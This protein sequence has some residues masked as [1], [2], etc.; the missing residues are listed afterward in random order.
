MNLLL[1]RMKYFKSWLDIFY[2][3]VIYNDDL[4]HR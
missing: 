1:F 2:L 4:L 3:K